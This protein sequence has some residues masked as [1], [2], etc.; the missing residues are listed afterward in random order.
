MQSKALSSLQRDKI[1]TLFPSAKLSKEI[2]HVGYGWAVLSAS[3]S[4]IAD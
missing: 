4:N 2:L 3:I 1:V